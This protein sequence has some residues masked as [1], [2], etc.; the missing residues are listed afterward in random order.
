[1]NVWAIQVKSTTLRRTRI[2]LILYYSRLTQ[3][4]NKKDRFKYIYDVEAKG[5]ILI[6]L[7]HFIQDHNRNIF[8]SSFYK[9]ECHRL[10]EK[11]NE[12]LQYYINPHK[13]PCYM[14]TP[15]SILKLMKCFAFMNF[16][17]FLWMR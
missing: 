6:S 13:C 2:S 14:N 1:M 9:K 8:Y 12:K 17:W 10:L 3:V 7:S 16:C 4:N 11:W 15:A 5:C